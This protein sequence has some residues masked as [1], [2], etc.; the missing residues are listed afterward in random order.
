MEKLSTTI[1][2]DEVPDGAVAASLSAV[3]QLV[4]FMTAQSSSED[5]GLVSQTP[6]SDDS[7]WV[8]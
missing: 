1:N 8:N 4:S 5:S 2:L 6:G 3:S 7:L